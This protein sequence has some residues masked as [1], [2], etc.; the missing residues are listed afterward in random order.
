MN[1]KLACL[2]T[3]AVLTGL[4]VHSPVRAAELIRAQY[5][6][7]SPHGLAP[8]VVH[9]TAKTEVEILERRGGWSRVR[10][11]G[12]EGWLRILALRETRQGGLRAQNLLDLVRPGAGNAQRVTGVAGIR[13]LQP[14][15]SAAH[16]LI[17]TIGDYQN[18]IPRLQGV[19]HDADS[20]VLM[21]HALAVPEANITALSDAAL[22]LA[23]LR[24]ALDG[25]EA[26]VL[27]NDEVFLYYSGHGTRLA[28]SDGHAQRCAAA[29]LSVTGEALLDS[30]LEQR[31]HRIAVKARRVVVF[32]DAGHAGGRS[33]AGDR[34]SAKFWVKPD[35]KP[36][37]GETC[38]RA[39]SASEVSTAEANAG[40]GKLNFI[41]IAAAREDETALD[42]A[43]RGGLASQAWLDCLAGGAAD[44]D[45]STGLSAR[46]L[47]ACAQVRIEQLV[48]E[49][50]GNRPP[51]LTLSGNSDMVLAAAE[52]ASNTVDAAAVLK[53]IYANRDDRRRVRLTPD[54]PAYKA[55]R[56]RVRFSLESSHAGYVYLL[57]AG[58]DGKHFDL[59]FPNKKDDRNLIQ[60]NEIWNLPRAGWAFRAGGPAGRNRL[61]AL[62]SDRPRDFST[63][64]M[65]PA[66][67]FSVIDASPLTARNI[68]IVSAGDA[69]A[70][71]PECSLTGE[72]RTADIA[73]ACSDAY[74]A[75]LIGLIEI[76]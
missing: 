58:S 50:N 70:A 46:E 24:A 73:A 11:D 27:P 13:G 28:A 62:V 25:L 22:T 3:V 68:Q 54:K 41:R 42:D 38:K 23:G 1:W 60:A 66:G 2:L 59:L 40:A 35:G 44:L 57:M 63:L 36:G 71:L 32:L 72:Q 6:L 12:R 76:D 26:R 64:G 48:G 15:R 34:F 18:G 33:V 43:Q 52:N 4:A 69:Q 65:R 5:L 16:A 29:L 39:V 55:G 30:E 9:L 67:P 56:D 14:A 8:S 45:A 31:L 10:A 47:Q 75:D 51:H 53:D 74:G 37:G 19:A 61:L 20:A 7:A 17:L 21:A 49:N